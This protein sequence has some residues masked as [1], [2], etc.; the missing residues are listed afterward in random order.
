[1]LTSCTILF[2]N[3]KHY[4]N[5][6]VCLLSRAWCCWGFLNF[7]NFVTV[8]KKTYSVYCET[9]R[10]VDY[11]YFFWRSRNNQLPVPCLRARCI[12]FYLFL[13]VVTP[14]S[15]IISTRNVPTNLAIGLTKVVFFRKFT[16]DHN[17]TYVSS[18]HVVF[19]KMEF[20][21]VLPCTLVWLSVCVRISLLMITYIL[22]LR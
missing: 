21:K 17:Y 13:P 1:M 12:F 2:L 11:V 7:I 20:V 14:N 19:Y 10:C 6:C 5:W 4:K 3:K 8:K 18:C 15:Y 9:F 16:F 22:R